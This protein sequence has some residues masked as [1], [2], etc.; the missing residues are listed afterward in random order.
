M[1]RV[2]EGAV[3]LP[4][5]VFDRLDASERAALAGAVAAPLLGFA[6]EAAADLG[7]DFEAAALRRDIAAFVERYRARPCRDNRGGCRFNS[8]VSI[9]L[10]AR[11]V[12]PDAIIESGTFQG[13]SA[14]VLRS[15]RPEAEIRC[16]DPDLG[17]LLWHD[18]SVS[19]AAR[20]WTTDAIEADGR[21]SLVFFDDHVSQARRVIEA[22]DRGF[23]ILLFDDDIAASRLGETGV[24]PA[25]TIQ[26]VFDAGLRDGQRLEWVRNGKPRSLIVDGAACRAARARIA[27]VHR[28]PN[29]AR[30]NG[31]P[32]NDRLCLVRLEGAGAPGG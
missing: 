17:N 19:F 18:P 23:R 12:A 9:Y 10:I 13:Q 25:P 3:D 31:W 11:L 5:E 14:W 21:P 27:A 29:L 32:G 20:D 8:C 1:N 7:T 2:M 24:P 15:V 26:M 6:E 30:V 28:L 4:E 16:Y 22:H